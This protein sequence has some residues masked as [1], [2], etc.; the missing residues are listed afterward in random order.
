MHYRLLET[1]RQYALE[2]LSESDEADE[3]RRLHRDHY[4]AMAVPLQSPV[5]TNRE[6]LLDHA[7]TEI[8]NLRAAFAWSHERGDIELALEL[9]GSLQP[10]WLMRGRV[11]EGLAWL[12]EVLTG[13]TEDGAHLAPAVYAR[14]LA[15]QAFLGSWAVPTDH[16]GQARQALAMAREVD[17]PA[18]LVS[19]LTSCIGAAAFDAE[20]VHPYVEEA[21]GLARELGDQWRLGQ[22]LGWKAYVAILGGDP[23]T[24]RAAGEEGWLL[25]Q[26]AGDPFFSRFCRYWGPGLAAFQQGDLDEAIPV[27]RAVLAEADAAGDVINGFAART[28]LAHVLV[29]T[30]D[31]GGAR[32]HAEAALEATPQLGPYLQTW[33]S[34][35]LAMAALA[36]GDL[37]AAA[38]VCDL[39]WQRLSAQPKNAIANVNPMAELELARGDLI[40]ARRCADA[41]VSVMMGWHLAKALV[42]RARVACSQG[43]FEQAESDLHRAL[44][45]AAEYHALQVLPDAF[46]VLGQVT[47]VADEHRDAARLFGVADALRRRMGSV[48]YG[49]YDTTYLTSV[50]HV[51]EALGEN[52]FQSAWEEGAGMTAEEAIAYAQRGRGARKRPSSGWGSLTPTELDVVRLVREGFANKD[53]ATR[54]FISPRTVQTHLT[55]VYTKLG[56]TS[57]VQLAQ[58]A[59]RHE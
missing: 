33:G 47:D 21:I 58:E 37:T 32:M 2:K 31:I 40:A 24:A 14:A 42:T 19:V 23:I 6:V 52:A 53:V 29:V 25:A 22:I 18:L 59:A 48:R 30:G 43:D 4:T 26:A 55:H 38:E 9:A 11:Q 16:T 13:D 28:G 17:D 41:D 36:A 56:L 35:P 34:A 10:L 27:L 15:D 8:D 3:V 5:A 49:V 54:L 50:T 44:A 51:S 12:N 7:E 20:A 39:V 46:E 45:C 1:V 57:R